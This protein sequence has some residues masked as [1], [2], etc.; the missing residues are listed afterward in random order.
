MTKGTP[1]KPTNENPGSQIE[2]GVF[3]FQKEGSL[4]ELTERADYF[5]GVSDSIHIL[6]LLAV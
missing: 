6:H 3:H 4:T 1:W 2:A 5:F